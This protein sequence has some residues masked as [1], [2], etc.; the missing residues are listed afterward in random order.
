MMAASQAL[1]PVEHSL[2]ARTSGVDPESDD[3]GDDPGIDEAEA[4]ARDEAVE[5][6]DAAPRW[7]ARAPVDDGAL[8]ALLD[9][10]VARDERSF[11]ALYDAT[12]ARVHGLVRRIVRSNP[13]A[14]EVVEDTYWQV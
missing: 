4:G 13:L 12:S 2:A 9:R 5:T 11:A 7:V 1:R 10:V 3:P 6:A 8:A 14:E